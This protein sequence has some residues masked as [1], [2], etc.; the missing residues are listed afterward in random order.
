MAVREQREVYSHAT[1]DCS[2]MTLTEYDVNGAPDL[3]Y[4]GDLG[5]L[6]RRTKH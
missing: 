5:A 1:I 2:D 6:G 4:Q 3:R